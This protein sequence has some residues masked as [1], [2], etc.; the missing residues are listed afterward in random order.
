[1]ASSDPQAVLKHHLKQS[2]LQQKVPLPVSPAR[3]GMTN[4]QKSQIATQKMGQKE[5]FVPFH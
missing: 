5:R 1:M 3:V 4:P 2:Q